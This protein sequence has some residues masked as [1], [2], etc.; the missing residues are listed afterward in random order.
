MN[1]ILVG[2]PGVGKGTQATLLQERTGL[3]HVASGDLFRMHVGGQTDLGRKAR[4]Y[5]DCGELVPDDLVVG[6]IL[7]R[8]A[9]PDCARGVL[10]DGFPRTVGQAEILLTELGRVGRAVHAVVVLAAPRDVLLRRLVGRQTCRN[11]GATF[12]IFYAPSLVEA[13]CDRCG[14]ELYTRS[15]DTWATARHR[16]DV[17]L[18]QT[19]PIVAFFEERGLVHQVD[20]LGE[21][22]EVNRGITAALGL[23][24]VASE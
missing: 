1:V 13:E 21:V 4:E 17:Y 3:A 14:G 7:D 16:L 19:L 22:D 2:A 15:D 24:P 8:I 5:M 20:G 12:N 18:E 6:M 23:R 10:F 11:C 9:A